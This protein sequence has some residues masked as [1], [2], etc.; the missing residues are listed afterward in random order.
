[1]PRSESSPR[2]VAPWAPRRAGTSRSASRRPAA[3]TAGPDVVGPPPRS[4]TTTH[5]SLMTSSS[6]LRPHRYP[7]EGPGTEVGATEPREEGELENQFGHDD[8]VGWGG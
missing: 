3:T 6:G 2:R 7:A 8:H 1:M 4:R 5:S